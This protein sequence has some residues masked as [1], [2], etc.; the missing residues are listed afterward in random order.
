MLKE[1]V[2]IAIFIFFIQLLIK[3][4]GDLWD[5]FW[6][7]KEKTIKV[8]QLERKY[9]EKQEKYLEKYIIPMNKYLFI[10]KTAK[11]IITFVLFIPIYMILFWIIGHSIGFWLM[12]ALLIGISIIVSPLSNKIYNY[13]LGIF[14]KA[15]S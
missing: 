4:F 12:M 10:S 6:K 9:K 8:R 11:F 15:S 5:F 3:I 13:I 7:I 1:V 2:I 14:S